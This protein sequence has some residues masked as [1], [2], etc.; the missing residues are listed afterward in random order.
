MENKLYLTNIKPPRK[1]NILKRYR[2][3]KVQDVLREKYDLNYNVQ[4]WMSYDGGWSYYY[5]GVGKYVNTM[6]E[7]MEFARQWG[8]TAEL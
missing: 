4:I 1:T 5:A 2:I 6:K 8:A 3:E 7:A